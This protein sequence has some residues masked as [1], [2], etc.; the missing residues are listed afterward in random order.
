[1]KIRLTGSAFRRT[2]IVY[3]LGIHATIARRAMKTSTMWISVVAAVL[4]VAGVVAVAA[5]LWSAVGNSTISPLGWLA[6][7]FGVTATLA[8]GIG[9][10]A[11]VFISNRYGYDDPEHRER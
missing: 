11:L 9:L 2:A 3:T 5:Q 4:A 7:G 8:L 1:V 6:L 10:M